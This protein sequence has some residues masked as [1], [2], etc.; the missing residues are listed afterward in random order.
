MPPKRSSLPLVYW[1]ACVFISWLKGEQRPGTETT[2]LNSVAADIHSGHLRMVTSVETLNEVLEG[3][4]SPEDNKRFLQLFDRSNIS[5]AIKDHR[6]GFKAREL[7]DYY[8]SRRADPGDPILCSPDA[9]HLATAIIYNAVE[10]HTFD[11]TG[12]RRCLG[13]LPL[14][15]NVGGYP[16]RVCKPST[17]QPSLL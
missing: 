3:D 6:V 13:L 17:K 5:M 16:M 10:F 2:D 1:D 9:T 8:K 11:G 14:T 15:G 4:L 12:N 7:R